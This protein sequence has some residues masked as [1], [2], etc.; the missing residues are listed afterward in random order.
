MVG[1]SGATA[2]SIEKNKQREKDSVIANPTTDALVSTSDT[3]NNT[4]GGTRNTQIAGKNN[5]QVDN[6]WAIITHRKSPE[7]RINE[8]TALQQILSHNPF[9]AIAQSDNL[10]PAGILA[11][12]DEVQEREPGQKLMSD[13]IDNAG[14]TPR[15]D[16]NELQVDSGQ[17]I[18]A[19]GEIQA[20]D[21]GQRVAENESATGETSATE[22]GN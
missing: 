6:G 8:P 22:S 20:A 10:V 12:T 3:Q 16:V 11:T 17:K 14:V 9:Q 7:I 2:D 19:T 1:N 21:S 5:Q 13:A 15:V 4:S 18:N